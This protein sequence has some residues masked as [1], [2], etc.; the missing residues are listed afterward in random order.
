MRSTMDEPLQS[1]ELR[2]ESLS[3]GVGD[4][5]DQLLNCVRIATRRPADALG[6]ARGVGERLAKQTLSAAGIKPPSMLD[7]CL[8]EMEK[9]EVMSRGLIPAEIISMLHKVRTIGNKALHDDLRIAV[10][11]DDVTSVMFDLLLLI[12]WYYTQFARGPKLGPVFKSS[13]L[14]YAGAIASP[15]PKA[16]AVWYPKLLWRVVMLPAHLLR[17]L[18]VHREGRLRM[19]LDVVAARMANDPDYYGRPSVDTLALTN[20]LASKYRKVGRDVD[21]L[22]ARLCAMY[23]ELETLSVD[24]DD[25]TIQ[26]HYIAHRVRAA[27]NL[28][29]TSLPQLVN[30]DRRSRRWVA[31]L[32][33]QVIP[34]QEMIGWLVKCTSDTDPVIAYN[35]I[36]AIWNLAAREAPNL[37][38][39]TFCTILDCLFEALQGYSHYNSLANDLREQLQCMERMLA[40]C[41]EAI[42]SNQFHMPGQGDV[43]TFS[44]SSKKVHW[45][46]ES[47][48]LLIFAFLNGIGVGYSCLTGGCSTCRVRVVSGKVRYVRE[49]IMGMRRATPP[50]KL[51]DATTYCSDFRE[52]HSEYLQEKMSDTGFCLTCCC[53]PD[54]PVTLD[55]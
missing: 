48:N 53:R 41:K 22:L 36:L 47:R 34:R 44:K 39:E 42:Y 11:V 6:L 5:R 4:A 16:S 54:G 52:G 18:F 19:A 28:V 51:S 38:T 30:S 14:T 50:A 8:R 35:A 37:S 46:E 26:Y 55:L 23:E 17:H 13:A 27:A 29:A 2:I 10:S 45:L 3:P 9:P 32:T 31:A 24:S 25:W 40:F 43:I 49:S 7:A 15:L 1:I 20:R 33:M 12:R 21:G